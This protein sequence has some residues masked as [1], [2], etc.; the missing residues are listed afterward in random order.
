ML[1]FTA[2]F[3]CLYAIYVMLTSPTPKHY[4]EETL[5]L[6]RKQTKAP[7]SSFPL[8]GKVAIIT[9]A[10]SGLGQEIA[11]ELYRLG[12]TCILASRSVQKLKAA[13]EIIL[14]S[15]PSSVG[16]VDI[17]QLDTSDLESVRDFVTSFT[18]Q[19][20]NTLHY[21]VNNAGIHYISAVENAFT[22]LNVSVV[23]KQGFDLVFATNYLG[24]FLLT[25]LLLPS[26]QSSA[27]LAKIPSRIVAI[28][29]AKH[30]ESDGSMLTLSSSSSSESGPEAASGELASQ[31][32]SHRLL[33]YENSKL[34]QVLHIKE[35]QRRVS[36]SSALA[37]SVCPGWVATSLLPDNVGGRMV[38]SL[39]YSSNAAVASTMVWKHLFSPLF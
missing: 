20:E 18:S 37:F 21:L 12:A 15:F 19:Y 33:S 22:A 38:S 25:S 35:L 7:N 2:L 14:Q 16:G 34:A 29:S 6:A 4:P 24:H 13:Q 9:G 26:L 36:A 30:L 8:E 32:F 10:T 39:A 28:S 27:E 31:S 11:L 1:F 23:S 5:A 17:S 3:A